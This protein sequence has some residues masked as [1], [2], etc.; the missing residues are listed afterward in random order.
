[1]LATPLTLPRSVR[2]EN[3]VSPATMTDDDGRFENLPR[4]NRG[5]VEIVG[6]NELS[7]N[8]RRIPMIYQHV[9]FIGVFTTHGEILQLTVRQREILVSLSDLSGLRAPQ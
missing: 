1:M 7:R 5:R 6:S 8:S 4:A 2:V 9:S 3:D